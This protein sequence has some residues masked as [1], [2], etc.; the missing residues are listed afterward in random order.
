MYRKISLIRLAEFN[1]DF[2]QEHP[3]VLQKH[4]D[5]IEEFARVRFVEFGVLLHRR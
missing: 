4:K 2:K 3:E 5:E 1:G